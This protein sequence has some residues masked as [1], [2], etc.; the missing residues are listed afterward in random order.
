MEQVHLTSAQSIAFDK[1]KSFLSNNDADIFILKGYAGTGKTTLIKFIVQYLKSCE[2]F[3][4]IFAPTGRAAKILRDKIGTG[5]TIH[6]G[7]YSGKLKCIETDNPD[8]S[9]K[10]FK[11]YFPIRQE[12]KSSI[13]TIVD[14]S[15]M[16]SDVE[17]HNEFFTFG[18]GKLLSDLLSYKKNCEI[19][20][21]IFIGDPAQLPPVTDNHSKALDE[22]YFQELGYK[23]DSFELTEVIRQNIESKILIESVKIRDLLLKSKKERTSFV[24]SSDDNEI[25]TL[26][27]SEI[28]H[29]Y[30]E[31]FPT[32]EIGNG[33]IIS[34]SNRQCASSNRAVRE[35]IFPNCS[36]IQINDI[37]LVTSNCYET[38]G[39]DLFNGDMVKVVAV[40]A[41]DTH[42]NIPVTID[43]EKKHI[44][45]TFRNITIIVQTDKGY[46]TFDC[47]ILEDFLKSD[48][49]DLSAWE[50]RALYIDFRMRIG[51]N[52][53]EGSE[54]FS[55]ELKKDPYFNALKVKF[56]YAITCHKSQGGEWDTVFVDYSG[57]SGVSDD[58]LRWCY[59][60]TTRAKKQLYAANAPHITIMSK[61]TFAEITKISKAPKDFWQNNNAITTPYH[62]QDAPL[63]A[64]L[65]CLGVIEKLKETSIKISNVQSFNYLD[66][67]DFITDDGEKFH[68]DAYYDGSGIFK[69]LPELNDGSNKDL[70]IKIFNTACFVPGIN[71]QPSS[72]MTEEL[73]QR[74][75]SAAIETGVKI[76]NVIE[77]LDRYFINYHFITDA[78]FATI[79]FFIQSGRLSTAMPRSEL[80]NGD[81]KFVQLINCLSNVI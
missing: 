62:K 7:I 72:E 41:I 78:R 68:I 56:G 8:V 65:K 71:Y 80:G 49:K 40:G 58:A 32:P 1:I 55:K 76:V 13:V 9:K 27:E 46:E 74:I 70:I 77:E 57:R 54:E 63:G 38:F 33:V 19:R 81:P 4:E 30:I 79:Q 18:S 47:K 11:F 31:T 25:I 16:I 17:T 26:K 22:L 10:S 59:T 48:E 15:S 36:D 24:L 50:I 66:K 2:K 5:S 67:Y 23:T 64:K 75:S 35:L 39:V 20:K 3:Y 43:K 61:L 53:K 52:F 12:I 42:Q 28:A 21:I 34:Y 44:T 37:L 29:K 60:A 51:N 14:E 69:L 73:W 6:K 45:L